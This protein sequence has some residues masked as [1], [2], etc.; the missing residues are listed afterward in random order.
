M[1]DPGQDLSAIRSM[2][3]K[4]SRILSLSGVAG[5]AI[6]CAALLGVVYAHYVR[7]RVPQAELMSHLVVDAILVLLAAVSL[8]VVFSSRMAMKKGLPVWNAAAKHLVTELAIPLAA[9]GAFCI[10]LILH[11]VFSLL[12]ATMLV[13]YGLALI[14]ASK[15]TI[16]EVRILG[17]AQVVLGI[18][19]AFVP[20]E[21]LNFWGLGFGIGHIIFGLRVYFTYER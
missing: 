2:M 1:H 8:A 5:I 18:L 14:S 7:T 19:A 10:A 4:S 15:Y 21:G 12:P 11:G 6:G 16:G 20:A 13:F 17:M 9:G 3:E